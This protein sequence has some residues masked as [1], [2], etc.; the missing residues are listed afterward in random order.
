MKTMTTEALRTY[1]ADCNGEVEERDKG[2]ECVTGVAD[3]SL[4]L[5][6]QSW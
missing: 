5:G 4:P 3:Q 1:I 6:V 2:A